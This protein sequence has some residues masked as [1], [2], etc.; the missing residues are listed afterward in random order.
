VPYT[1]K[2]APAA[3]AG[4]WDV[5]RLGEHADAPAAD[6]LGLRGIFIGMLLSLPL[7]GAVALLV[8]WLLRL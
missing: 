6:I 7:W 8:G 2:L 1:T 4:I 3:V 5:S